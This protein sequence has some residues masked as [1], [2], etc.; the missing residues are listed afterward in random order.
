MHPDINML[1]PQELEDPETP[2]RF[3]RSFLEFL[4]INHNAS[5]SEP[6][7]ALGG[8]YEA[9]YRVDETD[10]IEE[11]WIKINLALE[12]DSQNHKFALRRPGR[13]SFAEQMKTRLLV[14]VAETRAGG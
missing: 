8:L 14:I 1:L 6:P 13:P 3:L 4:R 7:R 2:Y 10:K 9:R 11:K 12:I 5:V